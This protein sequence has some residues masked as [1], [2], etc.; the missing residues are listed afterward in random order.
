MGTIREA[1]VAG[2]FY[3]SDKEELKSQ[4]NE[5]VN[6]SVSEE[7]FDDIFGLVVPHAGYIYSGST[8]AAVYKLLV[9]K[10]FETVII[11]SPSH[12]EY[13]PGISIYSGEAYETPLGYSFVDEKKK[14]FCYQKLN[15]FLKEKKDIELSMLWKF[16]YLF[17]KLF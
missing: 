15:I 2:T 10:N 9:N 3:P 1:K 11:I 16:N 4:I 5:L 12:R 6:S 14:R 13:F 8:A 7:K 17:Y